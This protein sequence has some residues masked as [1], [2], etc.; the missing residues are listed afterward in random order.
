MNTGTIVGIVIG[1]FVLLLLLIWL[2]LS[3]Y[4][5][6][7]L[8]HVNP[9]LPRVSIDPKEYSG[10]WF[11]IASYPSWF[12]NGCTHSTAEYTINGD[13][14]KVTNRCIRDG[15]STEAIGYAYK[16]E[17]KGVLGVSFF[18]GIYGNYTV[19]YRDPTTSIVT[20]PDQKY[21][22][23]LSRQHQISK[24]RK[25]QL[26]TWLKKHEFE[27]DKLQFTVQ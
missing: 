14:I 27:T 17:Q 1:A 5:W 18:P 22:W 20:D 9:K 8:N 15:Q 7:K 12:E 25:T 24:K 4:T 10:K 2:F 19:V 3:W 13:R 11:E 16:T 6:R 23:I 21:L 26:I